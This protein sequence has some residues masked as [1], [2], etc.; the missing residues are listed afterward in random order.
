MGF[1]D[2]WIRW[3]YFCISTV[4]FSVLINRSPV[5]FF[6][7]QKGLRQGD[8]LSPYLF[9]LAMEGLSQLLARAKELQW[10]QGFQVG[11]NPATTVNVSHLLYADDT[12]IF[13]GADREQVS[14]LNTTLIV[15]EAISGL[16]INMLKSAIYLVNQVD[17]LEELAGILSCK[18]GSLPTTYL[19]LLLG[20][21]FKSS[22][23]WNGVIEKME[24]RLATWKMQYLS[25]GGRLTL[26]NSVLD[27]IPTYCMSLFP[28]PGSILKQIDRLRRRFLW[29]GN[30]LT[31]KYSLVKWK[32]VTQPK[33]QGGLGIR[34]LQLH[35][36]SLLMKW[37]W[38]Y[39]QTEAGFWRDI[40]KAK[41][42]I[43]DRWCPMKSTEPHALGSGNT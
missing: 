29:E 39:G 27:S 25:M 10:I 26:I 33:F 5:G 37:L 22:G 30:S 3:I 7:T 20:A 2:R 38:R 1:G 43:Q 17:N 16:Y 11:S 23:I 12:L 14:N 34:N 24:K 19:G 31:H 35:N 13:C 15:F 41:Y 42:G 18:I 40:I 4:K 28:I 6:S 9:I 36:K 21:S 8:P 32:S